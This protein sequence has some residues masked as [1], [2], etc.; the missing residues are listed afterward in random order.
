MRYFVL[1]F[2]RTTAKLEVIAFDALQAAL[3]CLGEREA[4]KAA[5]TEVVLL[6]AESEDA[7]RITHSRYFT[8]QGIGADFVADD[9]PSVQAGKDLLAAWRR[10]QAARAS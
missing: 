6:M 10:T 7:I 3:A 9:L 4:R 5:D 2:D 8:E 1:E